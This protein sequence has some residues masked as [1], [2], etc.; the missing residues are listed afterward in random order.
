M[1]TFQIAC[2]NKKYNVE[3]KTLTRPKG[4]VIFFKFQI[5]VL[6]RKNPEAQRNFLFYH[7]TEWNMCIIQISFSDACF[8][9]QTLMVYVI[10]KYF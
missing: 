7:H 2:T 3:S 4:Y 6:R 8:Q 1:H 10:S 9:L 5:K